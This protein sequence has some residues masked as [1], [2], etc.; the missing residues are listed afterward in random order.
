MST[1]PERLA[2]AVRLHEAGRLDEAEALYRAILHDEPRNPHALHLLGVR[3]HQAG[4]H[5]EALDLIQQALAAHGP[6]PAFHSNLA[7]VYLA[8]GLP[9]E[10]EAHCREALRFKRDHADAHFNLGVALR[11]KGQLAEAAAAFRETLRLS[12]NHAA[13][14]RHLAAIPPQQSQLGE[15]IGRLGE[16]VRLDPN[17]FQARAE[18]GAA[19]L[20][21]GRSDEAAL[22][23]AEVLRLTPDSAEAYRNLGVAHLRLQRPDEA[24]RCFRE[25][26][27][28]NPAHAAARVNLGGALE[29]QG[30][31][32]EA[33]A[34]FREVLRRDPSNA[35]ALFCLGEMAAAGRHRFADEEVRHLR[36]LAVRDDLPIDDRCRL[37]FALAQVLDST[38]AYDEAFA[39]FRRAAALRQE[40]DRRCGT[41]FDPDAHRRF[42]DRLIAAFTPAWF[43]RARPFGVDSEL[44]VFVVGMLR[45]GTSLAEQIVAS[46][47]RAHGA[48][49]LMDVD[50]LAGS[51]P[52]L[53][54]VA[55]EYPE[56]VARLG[57]PTAH[58]L[59]DEYLQRL[60]GL[61]GAA[62]RVIDK[63]P[64]NFL[65]LGLIATLFPK[66]RV[67]HCRRDP[68]DTCLSCFFQNFAGPF[69]F[70]KDLRHLG[71]Y[72]R[73][74]ERLMAHWARVLPLPI[75]ELQYEE[76]TADQEAVSRK[77]VAFCGLEWD[78]RCL[79]FHESER[80]VWTASFLQVRQPMYR[81]L[82]S[83]WKRYEAHLGPLLEARGESAATPPR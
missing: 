69:P 6:H 50:I 59:A 72:Y 26:L 61:G 83:R 19:L 70:T 36:Q 82:V 80:P 73:E 34:E 56:C 45:S 76:L 55:E 60:R 8:V 68:V 78:D 17:N 74:Y 28:L 77:M 10:A 3:A 20:A 49:E 13:A 16:L 53:S 29:A 44:P 2:Q 41:T 21:A 12:P 48:G 15:V 40:I 38:G 5:R 75:F 30:K 79:R 33:L 1:I 71:L 64:P 65:H 62:E 57:A 52:R 27:R 35:Q 24:V 66:A 32:D 37:N 63:F 25:A 54:R 67:I 9:V 7:A 39:H 31:L 42:V 11:A 47:P 4:R 81:R 46:H 43:E 51:L 58:V 22:H 23:L 18:L 14:R